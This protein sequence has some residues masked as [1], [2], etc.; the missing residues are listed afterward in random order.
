MPFIA[1]QFE[2]FDSFARAS[3]ID[4]YSPAKLDKAM[5][6]QVTELASGLLRNDGGSFVFMPFPTI[7]Q[8]AP[9]SAMEV[10]D[11]NGDG[12]LD[13]VLAQNFFGNQPETGRYDGGIGQVLLGTSDG[14]FSPVPAPTSGISI[15]GD[16]TDIALVDID[17]DGIDDLVL[18]RSGEPIAV[19]LQNP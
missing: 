17:G 15:S 6:L 4:I 9:I 18:A 12:T 2:D 19:F 3:L 5:H 11:I 16:A 14:S 10:S 1:S 8:I 13:L 7:A